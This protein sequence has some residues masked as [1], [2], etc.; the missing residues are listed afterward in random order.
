LPVAKRRVLKKICFVGKCFLESNL[1]SASLAKGIQHHSC[2][3]STQVEKA[4]IFTTQKVLQEN[5]CTVASGVTQLCLAEKVSQN[6]IRGSL[7]A[8]FDI[9]QAIKSPHKAGVLSAVIIII[10]L[11]FAT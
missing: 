10:E 6:I 2:N 4:R 8:S 1:F 7:P 5:T 11:S 3:D 9:C